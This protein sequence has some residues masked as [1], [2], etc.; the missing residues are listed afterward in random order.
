M[1]PFLDPLPIPFF[2]LLGRSRKPPDRSKS[3]FKRI[4]KPKWWP[5]WLP[6]WGPEA[7]FNR[8]QHKNAKNAETTIFVMFKGLRAPLQNHVFRI[9]ILIK[10]GPKQGPKQD[11]LPKPSFFG[12]PAFRG[13]PRSLP[14]G[15]SRF[16]QNFGGPPRGPEILKNRKNP[17][18]KLSRCEH[19]TSLKQ[20]SQMDPRFCG[21]GP[22]WGP[23]D[24]DFRK[25]FR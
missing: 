17:P 1:G 24:M 9:K 22:L 7:I 25:V 5:F 20:A 19:L 6:K 21:S 2:P 14:S 3:E 23:P 8:L 4:F 12:F 15:F 16:S 10:L 11:P 18:G 13:G